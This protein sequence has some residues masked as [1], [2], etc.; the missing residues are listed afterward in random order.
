MCR[1]LQAPLPPIPSPSPSVPRPCPS[2]SPSVHVEMDLYSVPRKPAMDQRFPKPPN[3]HTHTTASKPIKS[4]SSFRDHTKTSKPSVSHSNSTDD[5]RS[6]EV[7]DS[8][9]DTDLYEEMQSFHARSG[10]DHVTKQQVPHPH[11]QD[12]SSSSGGEG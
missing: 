1:N 8:E 3:S 11:A 6:K 10:M 4:H 2:P 12:E 7:A 9:D 5:S